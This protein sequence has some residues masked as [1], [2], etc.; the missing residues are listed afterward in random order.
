M[1]SEEDFDLSWLELEE[2]ENVVAGDRSG[3]KRFEEYCSSYSLSIDE[4]RRMSKDVSLDD[5]HNS[6][7]LHRVCINK[8][9]TLEIIEYLLDLYPP[10]IH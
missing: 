8:N 6:S 7:F 3:I 4:L 1:D 9:V 5:L 2:D 10:A